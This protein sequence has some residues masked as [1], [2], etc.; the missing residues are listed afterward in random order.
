MEISSGN[1]INQLLSQKTKSSDLALAISHQRRIKMHTQIIHDKVEMTLAHVE[2]LQWVQSF[3]DKDKFKTFEKLFR[4][5]LPT[6]EI[7]ENIFQEYPRALQA[8]NKYISYSFVNVELEQEF[9]DYLEDIGFDDFWSGEAIEAL[10]S[11]INSFVVLDIA[12]VQKEEDNRPS[13]YFYL[14]DIEAVSHVS[15]SNGKV[16]SIMFSQDLTAKEIELG[17]TEKK[18]VFDTERITVKARTKGDNWIDLVDNEHGLGFCPVFKFYPQ[19]IN[20]K[21]Q[22]N[23]KSPISPALGDL[24]KWLFW[25]ISIEHFKLYGAFPI[26]WG[27]KTTCNYMDPETGATCNGQGMLISYTPIE[28]STQMKAHKAECPACKNKKIIGA[29]SFIEIQAPQMK[30]DADLREPVGML[31]VQVDALKAITDLNKTEENKIIYNCTGKASESIMNT[32]AVNETQAKSAFETR[33][34]ILSGIARNFEKTMYYMISTIAKLRY[35]DLFMDC[36]VDLGNNFFLKT[37]EELTKD[38]SDC[39]ASGRPEFELKQKRDFIFITENHNNPDALI[40]YEILKALEPYQ[41]YTL[42]DL[43]GLG[44]KESD[45]INFLIKTNFSEFIDRFERENIGIV[46]FGSALTFQTK[47]QLIKKQFKIYADEKNISK[48]QQGDA[49]QLK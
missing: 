41:G 44:V 13:P 32:E 40:R 22:L 10:T 6:N 9:R 14:L 1:R 38:Y 5:P 18:A 3:L 49:N 33:Q 47:I 29:G 11:G 37:P 12:A 42:S 34:S 20:S 2:F 31:E 19:L 7:C 26:Y 48:P 4:L 8:R 36:S 43:N 25:N 16:D 17:Y 27:Y 15:I 30:E 21:N 45:P 46:E 24:D 35:G 23:S 39:K 28:G